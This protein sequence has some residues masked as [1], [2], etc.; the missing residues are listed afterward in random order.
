MNPGL[1][2]TSPTEFLCQKFKES[3]ELSN[4][5]TIQLKLFKKSIAGIL[6]QPLI[7]PETGSRKTVVILWLLSD[8]VAYGQRYLVLVHLDTDFSEAFGCF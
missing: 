8:F 4:C 3:H 6:G 2:A 1:G 5:E 7:V